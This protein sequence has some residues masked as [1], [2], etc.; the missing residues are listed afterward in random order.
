MARRHSDVAWHLFARAIGGLSRRTIGRE[1]DEVMSIGCKIIHDFCAPNQD[2]VCLT[3]DDGPSLTSTEKI[4]TELTRFA[5]PATFF[6]IGHHAMRHPELVSV[7][8]TAGHEVG[9]HTMT[10]PDLHRVSLARLRSELADCQIALQEIIR[11]P[12][13]CFRAPFGHF[14]WDLRYAEQVGIGH[15]VHWDVAPKHDESNSEI[16]S[17]YILD[18]TRPGS[19]ILLHDGLANVDE[20]TSRAVG[21]AAAE[22]ISQFVPKLLSRG[23]KF[24]TVSQQIAR[25]KDF[26]ISS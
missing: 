2:S 26:A 16:L 11:G 21:D 14:R 7:L 15:L 10:H 6:C 20:D 24:E 13:S 9:N 1:F 17:N 22:S 19:I 23:L 4:L 5:I 3:F 18:H 12:V 25:I 8:D